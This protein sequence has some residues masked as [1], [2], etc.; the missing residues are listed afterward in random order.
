MRRDG[1]SLVEASCGLVVIY[2]L[3][4]ALV[5][6]ASALYAIALNDSVCRNAAAFAASG[7]PNEA[8]NRVR[9]VIAQSGSGF[10][11]LISPPQLI[12]PVE[13]SITSEPICRRD[14]D[15]DHLVNPG[16][17]VTGTIKV[18]TQIEIKPF[19]IDMLLRQYR[20]MVFHASQSFPIHYVMPPSGT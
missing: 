3:G 13:I 1:Q 7:N 11:K 10:G 12:L 8:E 18:N 6:L 4:I 15:N 9:M 2:A 16:G 19:G 14:P 5:D 17:M 20:V